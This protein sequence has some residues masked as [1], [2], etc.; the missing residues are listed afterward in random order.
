MLDSVQH[1]STVGRIVANCWLQLGGF[2]VQVKIPELLTVISKLP[3]RSPKLWESGRLPQTHHVNWPLDNLNV[4]SIGLHLFCFVQTS[5]VRSHGVDNI[6]KMWTLISLW[7]GALNG[8]TMN[9]CFYIAYFSNCAQ[10]LA[11]KSSSVVSLRTN[12]LHCHCDLCLNVIVNS[13]QWLQG[14]LTSNGICSYPGSIVNALLQSDGC[15]Y[16]FLNIHC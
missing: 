11:N 2:H 9:Q 4:N 1:Q 16:F 3:A 15:S 13:G 5:W 8:I 10:D 12:S 7:R 14:K 6:M